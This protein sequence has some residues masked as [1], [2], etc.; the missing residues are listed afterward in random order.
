MANARDASPGYLSDPWRKLVSTHAA[1]LEEAGQTHRVW[2]S[3]RWACPACGTEAPSEGLCS[4]VA[5]ARPRNALP[6]ACG[7]GTPQ[8]HHS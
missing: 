6:A 5:D 2:R 7:A 3:D 1:V 4:C 8:R